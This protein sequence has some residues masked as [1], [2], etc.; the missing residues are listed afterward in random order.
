LQLTFMTICLG[1]A[2]ALIQQ[3]I[4]HGT[5][6]RINY[7]TFAACFGLF[8]L[9][10]YYLPSMFI[11]KIASPLFTLILDILNT[12][13]FLCGGIALAASLGGNNCTNWRFL[14]HSPYTNGGAAPD[15]GYGQI[16]RCREANSLTAFLWFTAAMWFANLILSA[17]ILGRKRAQ[18]SHRQVNTKGFRDGSGL[19]RQ[20]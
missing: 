12:I 10:F 14:H 18:E 11:S 7:A 8:T 5:P 9:L 13:F 19:M 1:L 3:Q 15:G 16:K 20:V 4:H 17:M 6:I 2:G